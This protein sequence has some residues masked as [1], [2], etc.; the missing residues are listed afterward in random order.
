MKVAGIISEY[1]PIHDGHAQ[2]IGAT[3]TMVGEE[4]AVV[5][6]LSGNFVQ[7]GDFAVFPKH[8]RAASAV[9]CGADL[10]IELPLPYVLSSAEGFARGAVRLLA[11]L[12]VVTHL[13]FG[14]EAGETESLTEIAECLA[15]E[16][17]SGYV[18]EELKF[19][20]SYASAR[21]RAVHRILGDKAELLRTPNNILAVEYLKALRETGSPMIPL[22]IRRFGAAH[23]SAGSESSSALRELLRA[24]EWPW[25]RM[26]RPAADILKREAA[27]LRG[28]VFMENAET[29]VLS[30]LRM[31]PE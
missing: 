28:P 27:A 31:L 15:T 12:G 6:V 8:A 5:C 4:C 14:S 11:A 3:R 21:Q 16:E 18:G 7:R 24:G 9:A 23:D 2:H 29:A 22:T 30:R 17:L 1:N 10:V 19:G 13:S 26:P 20:I 25:D